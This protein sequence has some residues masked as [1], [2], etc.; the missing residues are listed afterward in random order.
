MARPGWV[1]INVLTRQ[2]WSQRRL[3]LFEQIP[4]KFS[5]HGQIHESH[6]VTGQWYAKL[7]R[8][9]CLQLGQLDEFIYVM[10]DLYTMKFDRIKEQY[11]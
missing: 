1:W 5:L 8:T 7:G 9:I 10:I 11:L 4:P 2:K 3:Q 6:K